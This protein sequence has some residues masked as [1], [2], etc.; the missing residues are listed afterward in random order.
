MEA[1]V[2]MTEAGRV[3]IPAEV[4]SRLNL[5]PGTRMVIT[6]EGS[7]IRLTPIDEAIDRLQA[8]AAQLLGGAGGLTEELLQERRA[9]AHAELG[10]DDVG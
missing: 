2:R 3:V 6:V 1:T 4:R 7:G 9:A 8:R 5:K 10:R